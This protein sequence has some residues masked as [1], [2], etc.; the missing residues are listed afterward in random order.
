MKKDVLSEGIGYIT[1]AIGV[2]TGLIF[3]NIFK[4]VDTITYV[5]KYNIGLAIGISIVGI[6]I[7]FAFVFT[8]EII[9]NQLQIIKRMDRLLEKE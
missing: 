4:T 9:Y 6:L 5:A 1:M 8:G 2:I 3:G 7:G